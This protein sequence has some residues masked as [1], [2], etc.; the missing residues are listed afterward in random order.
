MDDERALAE[1]LAVILPW[2]NEQQRRVLLAAEAR[3]WG[4]GGVSLVA[5][6]AGVSRP[7][8]QQG[9]RDLAQPDAHPGRVRQVGGG[10]KKLQQQD[11]T[12]VADLEALVDA[13]TRGDPMS[14]LRWTCKSTRQLA[15]ALNRAGHR[16]SA[17]TVAALLHDADYSLQA[18]AKVLEGTQHPDRNAQFQYLHEQV[19]QFLVAGQPVVSMD[20][21]KKELIGEF[22]NGGQEWQP[23]GWP[24]RVHVHDFLDPHLGKA[25][26]YGIYD[27]GRNT[28]WVTV[29]QDHDTASF[30]VA[31]LRR[32]WQAVGTQ[33][34]PRADRLLICVDGG[35][36]NGSRLRLW[37]AEL[38]RFAT[39]MGL[40]VTVCHLPPGTSKWNLIEHRLF[41]HIS[42]NWR[43]RPLVSYEVV[44]QL[45]G[46]TTT[47]SGLRVQAELD[48]AR[49]PT[50]VKVPD[51][52]MASLQITP[53]P[54][55]GNW[56]YT[57]APSPVTQAHL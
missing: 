2:L 25:L 50:K 8:I 9:F 21:K 42:M 19:K 57:L 54:F 38:Q 20:A 36:S 32:W 6:A 10:R 11:P 35:G 47:R 56:N 45:I 39:E 44:L 1:K 43:G 24:E 27:V 3:A 22:K 7:T 14:P 29:G 55:H 30:A 46:A 51:A 18:N 48:S 37:K 34:Y 49:Y 15:T 40:H 4:Y 41:A 52:E 5:R 13:E 12:L 28:G 26:P 33:A 16:V 31:T 17:R 53:H 23:Q